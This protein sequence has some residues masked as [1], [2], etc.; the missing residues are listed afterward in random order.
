[1]WAAFHGAWEVLALGAGVA[2][3]AVLAKAD[4]AARRTDGAPLAVKADAGAAAGRAYGAPLA[5][6]AEVG[7]AAGHA[8]FIALAVRALLVDAPLYWV[9][10]QGGGVAG[11]A[12]AA[13]MAQN[14]SN[15]FAIL[16]GCL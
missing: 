5:V 13:S 10:R 8:T 11:T 14:G 16:A 9:R 3:L 12:A 7:A 1:M 4:A 15:M 6:E 2:L